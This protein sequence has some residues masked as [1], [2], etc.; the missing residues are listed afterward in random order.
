MALGAV[1]SE[2]VEAGAPRAAATASASPELGKYRSVS[3]STSRKCPCQLPDQSPWVSSEVVCPARWAS[4][5]RVAKPG[6]SFSKRKKELTWRW[7]ARLTRA[8]GTSASVS[9]PRHPNEV[10]IARSRSSPGR[11]RCTVRPVDLPGTTMQPDTSTPRA[12]S[13]SRRKRPA[14]SSPT[15]PTN[16]TRRPSRAAPQA[17]IADEPPT[18]SVPRSTRASA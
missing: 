7:R 13:S 11:T 10:S 18:V 5:K 2:S 8:R 17:M 4:A 12:L 9:S 6:A 1:P 14:A 16:A 3:R 15:A